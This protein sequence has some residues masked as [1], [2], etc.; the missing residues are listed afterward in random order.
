MHDAVKDWVAEHITPADRVVEFGSLDINGGIRHLLE[1]NATYVGVDVQSGPGVT[2]IADAATWQPDIA[3]DLVV[4]LE[5]FEHAQNWQQII[6]NAHSILAPG[7]QFIATAAGTLRAPHSGRRESLPDPDEYYKGIEGYELAAALLAA[8]FTDA[9]T[10]VQIA[11][12]RCVAT[13]AGSNG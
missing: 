11:D 7:G 4:C 6:A 5:V 8:G 3:P 1:P 12:V 10:E 2:I 9:H 13:K